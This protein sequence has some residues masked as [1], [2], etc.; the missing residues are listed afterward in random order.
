MSRKVKLKPGDL[1]ICL[2]SEWIIHSLDSGGRATLRK[3]NDPDLT[4]GNALYGVSVGSLVLQT[5]KAHL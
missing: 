3:P 2:H 4:E 1:V 5:R